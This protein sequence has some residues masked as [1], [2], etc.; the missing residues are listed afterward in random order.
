MKYQPDPTLEVRTHPWGRTAY[1]GS[2]AY[3]DLKINPNRLV[4]N[5]IEDLELL[6]TEARAAAK[7]FLIWA[8]GPDSR[9]ETND[10]GAG[11]LVPN[12]NPENGFERQLGARVTILFRELKLNA[13][14]AMLNSF[15]RKVDQHVKEVDFGWT[16]AGW[17][18]TPWRHDFL[19]LPK[20]P[21]DDANG[22]CVL[23]RCWA[24][25]NDEQTASINF[26]RA[27]KNLRAALLKT[28]TDLRL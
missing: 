17:G 14:R 6:P 2:G 19:E 20:T 25:A 28:L 12:Q 23:Y 10:F 15:M 26:A 18:W 5:S 27:F 4:E 7:S 11:P 13:D 8:N 16:G 3:V 22:Y 1:A 21:D 24:W 9:L